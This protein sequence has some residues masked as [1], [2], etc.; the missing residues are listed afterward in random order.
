MSQRTGLC[1]ITIGMDVATIEYTIYR[2]WTAPVPF[3]I[4]VG[5]ELFQKDDTFLYL[6]VG[7][8]CHFG[9]R[10]SNPILYRR[11]RIVHGGWSI[12]RRTIEICGQSR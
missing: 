1:Q 6:H 11:I 2:S 5:I 10:Y 4:L 12:T 8:E 3:R 9:G 7:I